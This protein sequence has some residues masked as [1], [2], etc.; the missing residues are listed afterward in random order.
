MSHFPAENQ[1]NETFPDSGYGSILSVRNR[2]FSF[3]ATQWYNTSAVVD[4]L[5]PTESDF[6]DVPRKAIWAKTQFSDLKISR[7][8]PE[9]DP[10]VNSALPRNASD[11]RALEH[12]QNEDDQK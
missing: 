6:A 10:T 3:N 8:S 4:Q 7:Y 9:A 2:S 5:V 1:N 11:Q 12:L